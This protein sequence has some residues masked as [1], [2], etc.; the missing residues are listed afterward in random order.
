MVKKLFKYREAVE[1]NHN[2][3]SSAYQLK[4]RATTEMNLKLAQKVSKAKDQ[5]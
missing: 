2:E 3:N 4:E 5:E 1:L